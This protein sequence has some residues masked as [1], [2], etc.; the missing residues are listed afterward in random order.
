M[1]NGLQT[2]TSTASWIL[3]R[4]QRMPNCILIH[5]GFRGAAMRESAEGQPSKG[6]PGVDVVKR[7][8]SPCLLSL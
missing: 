2:V 4:H 6:E 7:W 1:L 3:I 5:R 8:K